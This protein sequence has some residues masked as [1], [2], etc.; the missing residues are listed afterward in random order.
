[1][2]KF[3]DLLFAPLSGFYVFFGSWVPDPLPFLD[4]AT[5]LIIFVKSMSAL[6]ID[7]TRFLP[8]L[9]KKSAPVGKTSGPVVDV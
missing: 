6:G 1:M 9:G 8:F 4:E 3:I 7:L 2:N 5:A